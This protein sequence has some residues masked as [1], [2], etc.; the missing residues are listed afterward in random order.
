MSIFDTIGSIYD[1]VT[2]FVGGVNDIVSGIS[3]SDDNLAQGQ[4]NFRYRAFPNDLGIEYNGHYMVININVPVK[5]GNEG[6]PRGQFSSQFTVL[7]SE[8]SKVDTLRFGTGPGATAL[9]A[10]V[11]G[12]QTEAF[13]IP[14]YTRRIAESVALFMPNALVYSSQNAYE[15]ISLTAIAGAVG[16]GAVQGLLGRLPIPGAGFVSSLISAGGAVIGQGSRIIGTPINPRVEVLYAT[17][18]QRTFIFEVLMAPRNEKESITIEEIVRTLRFHSA[19]E[20]DPRFSGL[21]FIPP[22][23]FDITFYN[24]GKENLAIPRINTCVLERVDVDYA[25]TG[26][27]FSSFSNGF[28]VAVRLSLGFREVEIIHKTRVIQGF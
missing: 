17:T 28:P 8:F 7:N 5:R 16:V 15:D 2:N 23:E 4:Y 12:G 18:P 3:V 1:G 20:I 9:G 11:S 19:P 13:A 22:A 25:P 10:G 27:G 6:T 21:T 14:R 26:T 24:K